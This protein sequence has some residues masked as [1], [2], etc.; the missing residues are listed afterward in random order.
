MSTTKPVRSVGDGP[1][2]AGKPAVG[3]AAESAP[4]GTV[5]RKPV[6]RFHSRMVRGRLYPLVVQLRDEDGRRPGATINGDGSH[7]GIVTVQPIIPGALVSPASVDLSTAPGSQAHFWVTALSIGRLRDARVEFRSGSRL[8]DSIPLVR[9]HDWWVI[10]AG[11][12]LPALLLGALLGLLGLMG[13]VELDW[14]TFVGCLLLMPVVPLIYFSAYSRNIKVRRGWWPWVLLA[15]TFALPILLYQAKQSHWEITA[16]LLD[17]RPRPPGVVPSQ[18][19]NNASKDDAPAPAGEKGSEPPKRD[20]ADKPKPPEDK[21]PEDAQKE[22]EKPKPGDGAK[23]ETPK[24]E[25]PKK[26]AK[27]TPKPPEDKKPAGDSKPDGKTG[28][29][30]AQLVAQGDE[31]LL[32]ADEDPAKPATDEKQKD[33]KPGPEASKQPETK[34]GAGT[35]RNPGR[36]GRGGAPGGGPPGGGRGGPASKS[37]TPPGGGGGGSGPAGPPRMP[38]LPPAPADYYPG[39]QHS[40]VKYRGTQAI[41]KWFDYQLRSREGTAVLDLDTRDLAVLGLSKAKPVLT[42]TYDAFDF[43]KSL[44]YSEICLFAA[45]LV[46]TIAYCLLMG[47]ARVRRVGRSIE[48]PA[49]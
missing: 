2:V 15:L 12:I 34:D 3:F 35:P 21:K 27:D 44:Q 46:L 18:Q 1:L 16:E 29:E 14:T 39:K 30:A 31:G 36:G 23:P 32:A 4:R 41:E 13:Q 19:D 42:R 47:P 24:A 33:D 49:A 45:L 37:P 7:G 5:R 38:P 43:M 40:T 28:S 26:D 10:I 6:V 25:D 11:A 48:M 22:A 20:D 17:N 9:S 8:L